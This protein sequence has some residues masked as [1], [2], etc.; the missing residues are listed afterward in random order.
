MAKIGKQA[1]YRVNGLNFLVKV[2]DVKQSYGKI[3]YLITPIK[4]SD[5]TW[6]EQLNFK[7]L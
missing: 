1:I 3:R 6:V 4:G 5:E 7:A 2:L